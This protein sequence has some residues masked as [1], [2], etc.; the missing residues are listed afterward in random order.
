M[1]HCY[2]HVL[3]VTNLMVQSDYIHMFI[4]SMLTIS[5]ELVHILANFAW[6]SAYPCTTTYSVVV[7]AQLLV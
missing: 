7:A 5:L 2:M 1:E 6:S 4:H 3:E